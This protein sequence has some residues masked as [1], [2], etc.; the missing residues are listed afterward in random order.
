MP[1]LCVRIKH[2]AC[3]L[4]VDDNEGFQYIDT[5]KTPNTNS[6]FIWRVIIISTVITYVIPRCSLI[7]FCPVRHADQNNRCNTAVTDTVLS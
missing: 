5:V 7:K 2:T 3:F 6:S 4:C 1:C